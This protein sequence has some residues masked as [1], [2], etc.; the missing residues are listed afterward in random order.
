MLTETAIEFC[1][2]KDY[3]PDGDIVV[4]VLPSIG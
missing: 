1:I 3:F 2:L 4:D